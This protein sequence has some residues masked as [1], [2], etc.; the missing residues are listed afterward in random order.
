[1]AAVAA[2]A[3]A[4]AAEAGLTFGNRNRTVDIARAATL[5]ST[6]R[7]LPERPMHGDATGTAR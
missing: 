7:P 4:A 6:L 3:G 5:V 1:M 2:A